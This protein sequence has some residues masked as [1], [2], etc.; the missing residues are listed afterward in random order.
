MKLLPT[1]AEIMSYIE[2]YDDA[3]AKIQ[4]ARKFISHPENILVCYM[5]I[6]YLIFIKIQNNNYTF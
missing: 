1:K 4:D 3:R 2:Q 5:L 6:L